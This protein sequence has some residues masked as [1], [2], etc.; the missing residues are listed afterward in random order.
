[1]E[2]AAISDS[3]KRFYWKNGLGPF[4]L[5]KYSEP[6]LFL[7]SLVLARLERRCNCPGNHFVD[8]RVNVSP[9]SE[10]EQLDIMASCILIF[11]KLQENYLYFYSVVTINITITILYTIHHPVFY[12][13][14]D[15]PESG[16][17]LLLNKR[18]DDG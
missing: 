16:V 11:M 15:V 18:Q 1:M 7:P 17:C 2:L 13:K 4:M 3:L 8:V 6:V 12:L 5:Q 10:Q 14:N 9:V